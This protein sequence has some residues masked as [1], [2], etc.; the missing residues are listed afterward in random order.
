MTLPPN[1]RVNPLVPFP[2][3]V[4]GSGPIT[5]AKV[6]GVWTLGFSA[7][8]LGAQSPPPLASWPTDYYLIYDSAAQQFVK[9][10]LSSIANNGLVTVAIPN[11]NANSVGDTQFSVPILSPF[12]RYKI[13]EYIIENVGTTASLTTAQFGIWTAAAAGGQVIQTATALSG[14]T[15]NGDNLTG[16]LIT[17]SQYSTPAIA[18]PLA[19]FTFSTL[20]FRITTPQGAAATINFYMVIKP[21]R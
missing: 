14:L 19:R 17:I 16:G 9:V 6:N 11:I 2:A 10:P 8:G 15:S 3:L 13:E 1:I 21:L 12:T 20:F 4:S 7:A 18:F 5:I